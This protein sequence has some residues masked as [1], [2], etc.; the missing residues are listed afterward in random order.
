MEM[1]QNQNFTPDIRSLQSHKLPG[2]FSDA[3]F[4]IFIHWGLFSVPA[5][6]P[7]RQGDYLEMMRK[8]PQAYVFAQQPYAEWYLNSLRI[9]G[10]P[11]YNYH[12][13]KYGMDTP[14]ESFIETFNQQVQNWDPVSWAKTFQ[15]AGAKYVVLVTKHHDGFLLWPSR[16]TNPRK[17]GYQSKRD[18]VGE[19]SSEIRS[20]GMRMGHYYSSALDWTFT[21]KPI[22]SIADLLTSGP[23]SQEYIDYILAHWHELI[24]VYQTDILWSDIGYPPGKSLYELFAYFYHRNPEGLV[25]DRWSQFPA[26]FRGKAG[27]FLINSLVKIV[28]RQGR[29]ASPRL[30]HCD[31]LTTEY[32]GYSAVQAKKWEACR[33]I[34]NSFGYNQFEEDSDYAS[35]E[36]LIEMLVEIVSRNGNLL[37][38]VGPRPDGSIPEPQLR[39]LSGIGKWLAVNGEAIYASRPWQV[40]EIAIPG[41]GK[42]CFTAKDGLLYASLLGLPDQSRQVILPLTQTQVPGHAKLLATG[43]DLV[44]ESREQG[45]LVHLPDA[46]PGPTPVIKFNL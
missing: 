30:P 12:L 11:T 46:L 38:N 35:A 19:L 14:Y 16:K 17:S 15:Q 32:A 7:T 42:A 27:K 24:D 9:S 8:Y 20:S 22:L 37:L 21:E 44:C 28:F 5:Y 10:S 18:I 43:T 31:Y 34:G 6:A 36:S 1:F 4:G 3:K 39:A 29:S 45:W 25:N 33:G 26:L 23:T 40:S 2:W 41:G 13:K